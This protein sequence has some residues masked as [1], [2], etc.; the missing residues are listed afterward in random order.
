MD[1]Y[2]PWHLLKYVFYIQWLWTEREFDFI[3]QCV[4]GTYIMS[5]IEHAH[6]TS[7]NRHALQLLC[8]RVDGNFGLEF[9]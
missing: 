8:V 4:L 6:H 3:R 2:P 9:K 7:L 5:C 1:T